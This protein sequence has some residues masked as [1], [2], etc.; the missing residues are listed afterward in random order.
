MFVVF[1]MLFSQ[2]TSLLMMM[3]ESWMRIFSADWIEILLRVL[4]FLCFQIVTC[5]TSIKSGLMW[6]RVEGVHL[7]A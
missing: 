1:M 3:G 7:G 4:G 6:N 2:G 5:G